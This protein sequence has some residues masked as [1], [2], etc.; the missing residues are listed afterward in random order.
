MDGFRVLFSL[1]TFL[2]AFRFRDTQPFEPEPLK[3]SIVACQVSVTCCR[4]AARTLIFS[5]RVQVPN[6]H[7][8]SKIL[9]YIATILKPSTL[10]LGPLDP[11]GLGMCDRKRSRKRLEL[12]PRFCGASKRLPRPF[13][14][15]AL[16]HK[17]LLLRSRSPA[18]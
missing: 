5:L 1:A 7:I 3:P 13:S 18:A 15:K 16:K 12:R 11:W 6:N 4:N 2:V 14:L 9:S 17:D 8:L 10:L